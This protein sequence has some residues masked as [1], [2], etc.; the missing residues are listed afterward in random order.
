MKRVLFLTN[1]PSPYRIRFFEALGKDLDLTVLFHDSKKA[2][3]GRDASWFASGNGAFRQVQL[4]RCVLTKG[5][6]SLCLDVIDWL[7]KPFDHIIICGY[8]SPTAMLAMAYLRMRKIPFWMEVDGGLVRAESK[9]KYLFKKTLVSAASGWFSSGKKTTEYLLHY[10][11]REENIREYPFSSLQESDILGSPVSPEEKESLRQ[12]LG[13]RE[14]YMLLSIGQFIPRKGFDVLLRAAK[15]LNRD[16]GIYIVGGQPTEEYLQLRK[17]LDLPNVHFVGFQSK[18]ALA[19]F[20]KA[21]DV[22]VLPTREDIWG[23]VINEAMAYGLPVITTDRCVAGLELVEN[24]VNGYIVPV[25]DADALASAVRKV[26]T[27]DLQKMA[28]SSLG[29]IRPYT[30]ESMAKIHAKIL[31]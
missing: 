31:Q 27:G 8:S 4:S 28:E 10:G 23:L 5:E 22:F 21:A 25:E 6:D 1:I 20:Y 18:E 16:I 7:K 11:A 14:T 2:H 29:K 19:E 26:L 9:Y 3:S 17:E 12:K 15:T 24:A 13:V 30:I